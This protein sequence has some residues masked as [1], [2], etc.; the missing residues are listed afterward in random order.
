MSRQQATQLNSTQQLDNTRHSANRSVTMQI[1]TSWSTVARGKPLLVTRT[2][3]PQHNTRP[4]PMTQPVVDSTQGAR[5]AESALCHW[6]TGSMQVGGHCVAAWT[7]TPA[8]MAG[9]GQPTGGRV[10]QVQTQERK[11]A[12]AQRRITE[13][14]TALN[15]TQHRGG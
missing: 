1:C 4:M 14:P 12:G 13:G 8:L 3:T 2:Q 11:H 6:Q 9:L 10:C 5:C 7:G 15:T